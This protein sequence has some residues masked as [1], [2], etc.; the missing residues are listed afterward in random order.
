MLFNKRLQLLTVSR[1]RGAF[2]FSFLS[3]TILLVFPAFKN[4]SSGGGTT[5]RLVCKI[6][7]TG[8]AFTTDNLQNI[9]LYHGNSIRKYSPQG[10]LLYNYSDKSYGAIT[11]VDV[12]DPLKMLVFYKD[13]P[14]IVLLDNTLSQNGNPFSPSDVGYPLTKG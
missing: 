9:Y 11:S 4:P 2:C 1:K 14:E 13:F 5:Y 8:G 12:N 10:Q 6:P 3:I 7:F